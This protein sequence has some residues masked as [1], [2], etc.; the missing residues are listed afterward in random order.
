MEATWFKVD[1]SEEAFEAGM[2]LLTAT[3]NFEEEFCELPYANAMMAVVSLVMWMAAQSGDTDSVA[4]VSA[5][6][7]SFGYAL[8]AHP[9]VV[10]KLSSSLAAQYGTE[11]AHYH[12]ELDITAELRKV[13][14]HL[15]PEAQ[16]H[17]GRII[18]AKDG[19]VEQFRLDESE[20][21]TP[22]DPEP[23]EI[24]F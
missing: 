9:E 14:S 7:V 21:I 18:V 1:S 22:D 24:P 3:M 19:K 6:L 11:P 5:A 15:P 13:I 2:K 12:S 23:G 8:A 10:T 4:R 16:E 17:I 20:G